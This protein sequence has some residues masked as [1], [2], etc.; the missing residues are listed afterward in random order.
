MVVPCVP[1]TAHR[2]PRLPA[3]LP[4]AATD[5]DAD[6][7]AATLQGEQEGGAGVA[8]AWR[9]RDAGISCF[10]QAMRGGASNSGELLSS[11]G[12]GSLAYVTD[13]SSLGLRGGGAE[14]GQIR[15]DNLGQPR[16]YGT[17]DVSFL[18]SNLHPPTVTSIETAC[19]QTLAPEG[20]L[21][22]PRKPDWKGHH[23][24]REGLEWSGWLS[25]SPPGWLGRRT[26]S[27]AFF[28]FD[29]KMGGLFRRC[30]DAGIPPRL[31]RK[32]PPKAG[33]RWGIQL[34]TKRKRRGSIRKRGNRNM[35][36]CVECSGRRRWVGR[37]LA[38]QIQSAG[39]I[40]IRTSLRLPM[41]E[42]LLLGTSKHR[43]EGSP[44]GWM[45]RRLNAPL[46]VDAP[47]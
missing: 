28:L 22:F 40:A 13:L 19:T 39:Q 2:A 45:R 23:A 5:A 37:S 1:C 7:P 33:E 46:P 10:P 31:G 6:G 8:R 43:A 25:A 24:Q 20:P 17:A 14:S 3:P 42:C 15:W 18:P 35:S 12:K 26:A 30:G 47:P 29:K 4:P 38:F 44:H 41:I 9:G 11:S 21:L 27:A 34:E 36:Y 32:M 16:S